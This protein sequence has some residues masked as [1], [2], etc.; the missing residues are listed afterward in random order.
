MEVLESMEIKGRL[1]MGSLQSLLKLMEVF[2]QFVTLVTFFNLCLSMK[3][4]IHQ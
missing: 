3:M 2:P 4:T 1:C